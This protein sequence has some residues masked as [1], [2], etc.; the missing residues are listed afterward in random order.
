MRRPPGGEGKAHDPQR[1]SPGQSQQST[2]TMKRSCVVDEF[3]PFNSPPGSIGATQYLA[4][5]LMQPDLM[6]S[7]PAEGLNATAPASCKRFP[8]AVRGSTSLYACIRCSLRWGKNWLCHKALP[9]EFPAQAADTHNTNFHHGHQVQYM[10]A[11]G[12]TRVPAKAETTPTRSKVRPK[13][14]KS[15]SA[16]TPTA[17][18]TR[19]TPSLEKRKPSAVSK[20]TDS[21]NIDTGC[22]VKPRSFQRSRFEAVLSG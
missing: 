1:N 18:S 19:T 7:T 10:T 5:F 21:T 12:R 4:R 9:I 17:W 6:R 2:P 14:G 3:E 22:H 11:E 15:A 16:N 13:A 20:H 8:L